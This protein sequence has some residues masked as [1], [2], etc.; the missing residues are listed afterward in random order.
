VS[1]VEDTRWESR[2]IGT[3][4]AEP[5]TLHANPHNFRRHPD[6][7][8]DAL[9]EMLDSVGWV[10]HV[11]INKRSGHLVDGHLRVELAV[12]RG[13]DTIPVV[14]VDLAADEE[15]LVLATL[16]PIGALA[17]TD[18][19]ALADLLD[20]LDLDVSLEGIFKDLIGSPVTPDPVPA[21]D[22]EVTA[23]PGLADPRHGPEAGQV[24]HVGDNYL[25]IASVYD[26]WATYGPLL[27]EGRLLV[28][29]PTPIVAL[30]EQARDKTLVMVQPDAW[31]AGHLLDK[32]ADVRGEDTV[33]LA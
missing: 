33:S 7:Q 3:G 23:P 25:V 15:R 5:A 16:D 18:A 30:T 32:Y 31:L 29:Y 13:E 21:L 11:V 1:A 24:W 4:T 12:A 14:Y 22:A 28:P 17:D 20:G 19:D 10:Q 26:G 6:Y 8:R 27:T 9:G 2:I